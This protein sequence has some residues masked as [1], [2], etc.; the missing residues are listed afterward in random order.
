MH[1]RFRSRAYTH[2]RYI[3]HF[4]H[5]LHFAILHREYRD[6]ILY[7]KMETRIIMLFLREIASVDFSTHMLQTF[8]YIGIY[9]NINP[10]DFKWQTLFYNPLR[11]GATNGS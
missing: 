7:R 8:A 10:I 1:S 9:E 3:L 6:S 4:R 11:P 5:L 2:L